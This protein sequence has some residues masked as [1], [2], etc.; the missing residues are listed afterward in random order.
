[1][2]KPSERSVFVTRTEETVNHFCKGTSDGK[3]EG[4]GN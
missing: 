4:A 1:M 2:A 3:E